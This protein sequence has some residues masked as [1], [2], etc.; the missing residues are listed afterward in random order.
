MEV[1]LSQH[2]SP[3]FTLRE[4]ITTSHRKI[5]NRPPAEVIER[6]AAL[7]VTLLE[8]VRIQFGPLLITSGFRCLGLNKAIGGSDT[9]AHVHGCAAD[10]VSMRK[11]PTSE[12]VDWIVASDLPFD[13]V[14]DEYSSTSNW[15]HLGQTK[16]NRTAPRR[17][18]LTMRRGKYSPFERSSTE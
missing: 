11:H 17:Q 18:A 15:I 6:L 3:H 1:D 10:F 12:I 16:P 5:D 13:Q 14:I 7:C 4:M 2:L 9:S 8:P